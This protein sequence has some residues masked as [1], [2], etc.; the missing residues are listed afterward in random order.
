MPVSAGIDMAAELR[1]LALAA[2]LVAEPSAKCEAVA[3]IA[4]ALRLQGIACD[5]TASL[6]AGTEP[7]RPALPRLVHPAD[8]PRRGLGSPAGRVALLHAVAHIEFNAINLALDAVWRF[9][10]LPQA[11]YLD[12]MQVAAEEAVHFGLLRDELHRRGACYGDHEAHDGLWDMAVRTAHDPLVRMALVPRLLEA[13][14]LDVTPALQQRLAQAGDTVAVAILQRILDDEIGHVAIG[15]RWYRHLCLQRRLDPVAA[16]ADLA[17]R[18]GAASPR[19]PFN[20]AARV[21]AGFDPAEM[22]AW[23]R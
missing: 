11:Y 15:N 21:A 10:G 16:W 3:A 5:A 4:E 1:S 6:D 7:G 2:W 19:P 17:A 18:H 13:R 8:V 14:G 23:N 12:W 20:V 22:D 9:P